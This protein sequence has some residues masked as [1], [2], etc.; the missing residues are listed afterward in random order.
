MLPRLR[1][2]WKPSL[3][4]SHLYCGAVTHGYSS[5]RVQSG[6]YIRVLAKAS[7]WREKPDDLTA[8]ET[9]KILFYKIDKLLH[10]W[11]NCSLC[12]I[13]CRIRSTP[14]V[15]NPTFSFSLAPSLDWGTLCAPD[16]RNL[17]LNRMR[18]SHLLLWPNLLELPLANLAIF[19][20]NSQ[21]FY[22]TLSA[23]WMSNFSLKTGLS[24]DGIWCQQS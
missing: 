24:R 2:L 5:P 18:W 11:A 3:P 10:M 8:F 6:E 19:F 9:F 23:V 13:T 14:H 15:S 1:S 16:Y 4:W 17:L 22:K 20:L 7:R 21:W 12:I